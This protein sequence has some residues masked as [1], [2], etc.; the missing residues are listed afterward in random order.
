MARSGPPD[1]PDVLQ[2]H[3]S[4]RHRRDLHHVEEVGVA[5]DDWRGFEA[6]DPGDIGDIDVDVFDES[7]EADEAGEARGPGEDR[8]APPA[9]ARPRHA[10][11]TRA[12][13]LVER[14][15]P[16]GAVRSP[17]RRSVVVAALLGVLAVLVTVAVVAG[18]DPSVERPPPLPAAG[19]RPEVALT[20]VG[21][22]SKTASAES[23]VVSVVGK[24]A[25][26]GLITVTAGARVADAIEA[27]GGAK[28]ADLF[29]V[30]LARRLQDGEQ[31]YVGVPVPAGM[32]DAGTGG[33]PASA[34]GPA[35]V[36][37]NT[38]DQE[39]LETLP[40]VGEV[41]AQRILEWRT[42]HG[43]FTAV[44]QLREIDGIGEK[45]FADLRERVT[46]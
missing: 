31:V 6:G 39:Q 13:R 15:L 18:N 43:R 10:L 2:G 38:A 46:V 26:P 30:N 28:P 8:D 16:A 17:R 32:A 41:T 40:G 35:K 34:G 27:A 33:S 7:D 3:Q 22:S 21:V 20:T 11:N 5:E 45:R 42:G 1:P 37:L 4:S 36:N 12:G 9:S 25:K 19:S 14:W 29:T 24:V 44:E 23:L